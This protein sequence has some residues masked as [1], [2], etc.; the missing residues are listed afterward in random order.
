MADDVTLA[1]AVAQQI[2]DSAHKL[3]PQVA[4]TLDA[5]LRR[6]EGTLR[7]DDPYPHA[8]DVLDL[9]QRLR[10]SSGRPPDDGT[11]PPPAPDPQ[12]QPPQQPAQPPTPP[13]PPPPPPTSQ[14][15]HPT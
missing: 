2:R 13:A 11:R 5:D 12:K 1:L 14:I 10:Q 9:Q 6:I 4:R 3:G 8:M 15:G 7:R